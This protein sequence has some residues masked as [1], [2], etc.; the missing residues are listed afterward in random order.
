MVN[1]TFE[2]VEANKDILIAVV[3]VLI[4]L[5]A[6]H[7]SR[8]SVRAAERSA[9]SAEH[10]EDHAKQSANEAVAS[11]ELTRKSFENEFKRVKGRA[12][13]ALY[14]AH[15]ILDKMDYFD[16]KRVDLTPVEDLLSIYGYRLSDQDRRCLRNALN[17]INQVVTF[18][19]ANVKVKDYR[20]LKGKVRPHVRDAA[21]AV[22]EEWMDRI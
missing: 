13:W 20:D 16:P 10:S 12:Y 1:Q 7:Y 6:L 14:N 22:R 11:N 17:G 9:A 5:V 4:S 15:N 2:M 8:R 19:H 18:E 3:A 21:M